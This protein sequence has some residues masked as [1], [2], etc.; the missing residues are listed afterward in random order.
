[1][2]KNGMAGLSTGGVRCEVLHLCEVAV[3]GLNPTDSQ[4]ASLL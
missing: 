2:T 3:K 4:L 1:M